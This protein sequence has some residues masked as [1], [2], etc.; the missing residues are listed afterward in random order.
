M[1]ITLGPGGA[2]DEAADQSELS[3]QIVLPVLLEGQL[4][5]FLLAHLV[6]FAGLE[7][8][9]LAPLLQLLQAQ[10]QVGVEGAAHLDLSA[11]DKFAT[12]GLAPFHVEG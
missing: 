3:D 7:D 6:D 4:G 2:R 5:A 11:A 12:H 8:G 10:D 9:S 1:R